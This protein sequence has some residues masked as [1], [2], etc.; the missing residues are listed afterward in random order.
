MHIIVVFY[1]LVLGVL[2]L[3]ALPFLILLST[4]NKYKK[5]IPS[6]FFLWNNPPFKN[7]DVWIHACSLG[8]VKSLK[9]LIDSLH[10][11]TSISTVT[12]TGYNE[13]VKLSEDVRFLPF[14]ILLPFWIRRFKVLVVTEAELWLM[15]FFVAKAKGA[16]TIL[17]N[18][19]VSDRS[20]KSYLKFSWFY[21]A[22][23]SNIDEVFAQS[24][25]DKERLLTLGARSVQVNGNIKTSQ[26]PNKTK[27]F[28][29]PSKK[30][31]TLASTHE[32]EEEL[33]LKSLHVKDQMLIIVPRHPERFEKVHRFLKQYAKENK[34][35]YERFSEIGFCECDV[36]LCDV[37]GELINI[38]AIT[39]ITLLCG[40][41][42]ENVGGHN[43]L[44]P[45]FFNN[46]LI[47]GPYI[48][49]QQVLFPLIDD[50]YMCEAKDLKELMKEDLKH[51]S[52]HVKD[53]LLPITKK[54]SENL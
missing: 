6:R 41:F 45:A 9:P 4:K 18:A 15:L 25:K 21:R 3:L 47:C 7:E 10:V 33:L 40:S 37:M 46:I 48:F 52:L 12:K 29:K 53:A 1:F 31:I 24:Q 38:Y 34:K 42:V 32:D 49:N 27:E 5:S 51:S 13:A 19:R 22:I 23:F 17:I 43:P 2:W 30:V 36:L 11:K 39:D 44:E 50:V 28:K 14:E 26:I 16:K 54:I 35:S 20:Y 8:E